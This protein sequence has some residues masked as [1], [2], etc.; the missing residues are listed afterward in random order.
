[1]VRQVKRV[2]LLV[3]FLLVFL[4]SSVQAVVVPSQTIYQQGSISSSYT[5]IFAGMSLQ[6]GLKDYVFYRSGQYQYTLVVGFFDYRVSRIDS[7]GSVTYYVLDVGSGYNSNYSW[8]TGDL[9]SFS[10]SIS[11][12]D[13]LYSSVGGFPQLDFSI[14]WP[15]MVGV[16]L[17]GVIFI[18][19]VIRSIF[20]AVR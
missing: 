9:D 17:L 18:F 16:V 8:G 6:V 1:M 11:N 19:F 4:V 13:F 14:Y 20:K 3:F 2:F 5:S 10:L 15:V 7:V 12:D